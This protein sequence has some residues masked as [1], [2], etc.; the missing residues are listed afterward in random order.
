MNPYTGLIFICL[1]LVSY[2]TC[3]IVSVIVYLYNRQF[4]LVNLLSQQL[5]SHIFLLIGLFLSRQIILDES[6]NL[7]GLFQK[8]MMVSSQSFLLLA[9]LN[10]AFTCIQFFSGQNAVFQLVQTAIYLNLYFVYNNKRY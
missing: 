7:K 2:I 9:I 8:M 10:G 4:V 5:F 1:S 6:K 3:L